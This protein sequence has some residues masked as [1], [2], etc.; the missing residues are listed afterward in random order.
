MKRLL[1]LLLTL[2]LTG[3]F[4]DQQRMLAHCDWQIE[5][6]LHKH[7]RPRDRDVNTDTP[8][9]LCMRA[10]GYAIDASKP[11]CLADHKIL[12]NPGC[13]VPMGRFARFVYQLEMWLGN[14]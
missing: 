2:S 7:H 6:V 3:C 5:K 12:N 4:D 14:G 11:Q 1:P 13:Y 8:A 10:N 9:I